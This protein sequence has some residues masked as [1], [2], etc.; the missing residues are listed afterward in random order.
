MLIA[1]EPEEFKR[2]SV[3]KKF[4]MACVAA[5]L[6]AAATLAVPSSAQARW[7]YGRGHPAYGAW[8]YGA[9]AVGQ[10]FRESIGLHLCAAVRAFATFSN[11]S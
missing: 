10:S 5:V 9:L 6:V 4:L 2:G 8:G 3:M 1:A 11:I 7:G